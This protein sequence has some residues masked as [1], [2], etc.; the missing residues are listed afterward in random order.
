ML[1]VHPPHAPTH[2]WRDFLIHI[3]TIVVG[4]FIAVGLEQAVE[5]V[6]HEHQR[7]ELLAD[8]QRESDYNKATCE[9]NIPYFDQHLGWLL[10]VK[11]AVD[12]YRAD[13][14][15]SS[16]LPAEP[17]IASGAFKYDRAY[18]FSAWTSANTSGLLGLL[19]RE[20][21]AP[22]SLSYDMR[23]QAYAQDV[24]SFRAETAF[25]N[26][27]VGTPQAPLR[28]DF[29]QLN[30]SQLE[31]LSLAVANAFTTLHQ[32]RDFAVIY[33]AALLRSRRGEHGY[34]SREDAGNEAARKFPDPYA[35]LG[36]TLNSEQP[37]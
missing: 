23:E 33:Y 30:A 31:Q 25:K 3:A 29:S 12:Q 11:A 28:R 16:T 9:G 8:L 20:Q 1:D 22:F 18:L 14:T 24:V 19:S 4:L 13:R 27:L 2:T 21:S 10:E 15:R 6:H 35:D 32:E 7:S 34:P 36:T 17:A 5:Y 26:F 37:H